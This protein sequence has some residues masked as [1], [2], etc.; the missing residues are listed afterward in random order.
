MAKIFLDT[1]ILVDILSNRSDLN[2]EILDHHDLYI[3]VLSIHITAYL[4]K[5]EIPNKHFNEVINT[6]KITDLDKNIYQLA[7]KGPNK[8]LEDNIQLH[9]CAQADCDYFLT[10][11]KE[12]LKMIYF[13][14]TKIINTL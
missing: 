12:L 5:I 9:S 8:D 14:K 7:S 13:G 6:C 1:N 2:P 3:S 10:N 4:L 11:D